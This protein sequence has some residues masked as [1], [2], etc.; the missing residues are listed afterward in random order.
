MFCNCSLL[1]SNPNRR[2]AMT[3]WHYDII[4]GSGADIIIQTQIYC[5]ANKINH[6]LFYMCW[7]S[8][9]S[10]S[11][12]DMVHGMDPRTSTTQPPWSQQ[13]CGS[14]QP[15]KER[16]LFPQSMCMVP[17][18]SQDKPITALAPDQQPSTVFKSNC[19]PHTVNRKKYPL[20]RLANNERWGHMGH[21]HRDQHLVVT[22]PII[23]YHIRDIT[24][25]IRAL[26]SLPL[27]SWIT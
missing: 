5:D 6:G 17:N 25:V 3:R 27:L 16:K 18:R 11:L 23:M 15:A 22:T 19:C 10:C 9:F 8:V 13:H 24:T 26:L 1:S 4:G 12:H 7:M 20:I 2:S 14:A 21:N